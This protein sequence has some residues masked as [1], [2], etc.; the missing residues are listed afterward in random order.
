M[1][2]STLFITSAVI[3][4]LIGLVA[5]NFSL[6]ASFLNGDY[7]NPFYGLEFISV[8]NIKEVELGSANRIVI[9]IQQGKAEGIWMRDRVKNKVTWSRK[10]NTIKIDLTDEAKE[11]GFRIWDNDLVLVASNVNK[12]TS[13]PYFG[14]AAEEKSGRISGRTDINGFQQDSIRLDLGKFTSA[15]LDRMKVTKLDALIGDKDQG[16]SLSLAQ[17]NSFDAAVFHIPGK[18]ILYLS[19]PKIVKTNYNITELATVSLNGKVLQ[20]IDKN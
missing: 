4:I 2:T 7:K 6:K 3:V 13:R 12:F 20:A 9:G 19:D 1:K 11:S 8:T 15:T 14:N 17:E 16:A 18:G 10:G 5:C